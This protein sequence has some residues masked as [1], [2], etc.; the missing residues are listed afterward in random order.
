MQRDTDQTLSVC[1]IVSG[2]WSG[3]PTKTDSDDISD[4]IDGRRASNRQRRTLDAAEKL[5][6]GRT[7]AVSPVAMWVASDPE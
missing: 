1:N 3:I 4:L 7:T 6:N 5:S 2:P